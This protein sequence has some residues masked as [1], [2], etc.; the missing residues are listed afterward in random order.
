MS[1]EDMF[2]RRERAFDYVI[3]FPQRMDSR[4]PQKDQPPFPCPSANKEKALARRSFRRSS[5]MSSEDM[6]VRR[7]RAFDLAEKEGFAA[8]SLRSPALPSS[9]PLLRRRRPAIHWTPVF[10]PSAFSG[11]DS[12]HCFFCKLKRPPICRWTTFSIWRRRRDSNPRAG[13]PTNAFRV[14][15]VMTSSILLHIFAINAFRL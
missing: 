13:F 7:E 11:F 15:P 14:R 5:F 12:L 4:K 2:V 8:S 6:F 1:S 3:N 9:L 10:S